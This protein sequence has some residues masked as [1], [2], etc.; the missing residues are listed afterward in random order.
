MS[1]SHLTCLEPRREA[2]IGSWDS[3]ENSSVGDGD[4]SG[5]LPSFEAVLTG[6]LYSAT[7]HARTY[8]S[9]PCLSSR[10]AE[11]L[12]QLDNFFLERPDIGQ[13][14]RFVVVTFIFV[15]NAR[16]TP[17]LTAIAFGLLAAFS[18]C[19]KETLRANPPSAADS[20]H[21]SICDVYFWRVLSASTPFRQAFC[22]SVLHPAPR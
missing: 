13:R 16:G 3:R 11:L 21:T 8:F 22:R 15:C 5:F 12:L 7:V 4:D 1:V 9:Q 20:P 17:R 14:R 6:Q 18:L 19:G 10:L 2:E